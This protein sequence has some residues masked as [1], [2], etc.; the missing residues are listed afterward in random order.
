MKIFYP[1][2]TRGIIHPLNPHV[3]HVRGKISYLFD[4]VFV[5]NLLKTTTEIVP[6]WESLTEYLKSPQF[7]RG[8]RERFFRAVLEMIF[9]K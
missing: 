4:I 1:T 9:M 8:I 6:A 7:M 5:S 3:S 2:E